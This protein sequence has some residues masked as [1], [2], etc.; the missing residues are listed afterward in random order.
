MGD[1]W[2]LTVKIRLR[3]LIEHNHPEA[4]KLA[5]ECIKEEG[6]AGLSDWP[7]DYTIVSLAPIADAER[8]EKGK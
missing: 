5:L 6:V 1:D 4:A 8:E 3:S 2:E 7:D